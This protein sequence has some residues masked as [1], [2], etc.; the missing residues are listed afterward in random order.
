MGPRVCTGSSES[1]AKIKSDPKKDDQADSHFLRKSFWGSS[2]HNN[3]PFGHCIKCVNKATL[4]G[5]SEKYA[6]RDL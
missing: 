6:L 1:S 2:N 3:I 5:L 4:L